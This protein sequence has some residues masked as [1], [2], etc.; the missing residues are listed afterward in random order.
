MVSKEVRQSLLVV[1]SFEVVST[2]E[3]PFYGEEGER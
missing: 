3:G 1:V 2:K